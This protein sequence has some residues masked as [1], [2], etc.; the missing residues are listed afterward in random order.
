M[1]TFEFMCCK[2]TTLFQYSKTFATQIA[3]NNFLYLNYC[4]YK[5]ESY[6]VFNKSLVFNSLNY[7][8]FRTNGHWPKGNVD[9]HTLL[10]F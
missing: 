4:V 6:M 5:A 9:I 3:E 7:P 8:Y 10:E 1:I 2:Y